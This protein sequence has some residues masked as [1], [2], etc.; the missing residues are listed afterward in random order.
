MLLK[1]IILNIIS[2][3]VTNISNT[4]F[5]RFKPQGIQVN[6]EGRV[7]VNAV[8]ENTP[9]HVWLPYVGTLPPERP[10][11][12]LLTCGHTNILHSLNIDKINLEYGTTYKTTSLNV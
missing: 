3:I 7:P 2:L 5:V 4:S 11:W 10:Y 9:G 6:T 8:T 1:Y 12:S